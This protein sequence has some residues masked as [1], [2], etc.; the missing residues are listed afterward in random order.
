MRLETLT[1]SQLRYNPAINAR[2]NTETDLT[3]LCATLKSQGIGQPLLVRPAD[4]GH[5]EPVEGGRRFHAIGRLISEGHLPQDYPIPVLV[6]DLSD[7]EAMEL[8]LSTAVTRVPLNPA[9]EAIAFAKLVEGGIG[10]AEIA[11]HFGVTE[12]RVKQRLAIAQLPEKIVKALRA[13]EISIEAAQAFTLGKDKSQV[14]KLFKEISSTPLDSWTR[15]S[16]NIR[17]RLVEKR[18]SA[19]S[20]EAKFV[21]LEAYQEAGGAVDEDLFST[22][23]WVVDGKLLQK[24]FTKKLKSEQERLKAEGW[25]FVEIDEKPGYGGKFYSWPRMSPE[26]K[27]SA[28]QKASIKVLEER[29]RQLQRELR[30]IDD[31]SDDIE[32]R[33]MDEIDAIDGQLAT[34]SNSTFTEQQRA[35]AGVLILI[36]HDE[37][38]FEFGVM[39]PKAAKKDKQAKK[40]KQKASASGSAAGKRNDD[41]ADADFTG[42]LN[43]EMAKVMTLAMQW[44]ITNKVGLAKRALAVVLALPAAGQGEAGSF[45]VQIEAR[46]T[47][48]VA[49][50]RQRL[51]DKLKELSNRAGGGSLQ[52]LITEA[53]KLPDAEADN[54]L[55]EALALTFAFGTHI[56][57]D[58]RA[59]LSAFDPDVSAVWEPNEEF[60]KR[61]PRESLAGALGEAAIT[62][63]T[64]SKKKKDLVEMCMRDL[65]PL[66]WLPK[67]LRTPSYKGPGSNAWADAQ[68]AKLADSIVHQQAA[69]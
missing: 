18:V 1:F 23:A 10:Q 8:S 54:L 48:P 45:H 49:D 56:P 63:A 12:R 21:G 19:T 17:R 36:N 35:K 38:G 20:R 57:E 24:L 32:T 43:T 61:M 51:A 3:E 59:I 25:A 27:P 31:P 4:D 40:S 13:G 14:E 47:A 53:L 7:A 34:I 11:A 46:F 5:Y 9:D 28:D 58:E 33:L 29:R 39:E 6:R 2:G 26:G 64:S 30:D 44:A 50:L 55:A 37:V 41:D 60:F 69:E 16:D 67:P 65:L 42:A 52:Q 66:G 15:R 68:A 22:N 62:G